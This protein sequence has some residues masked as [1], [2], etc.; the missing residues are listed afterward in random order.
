[1]T[2]LEFSRPVR[3]RDL[4][5]DEMVLEISAKAEECEALARR[6]GI[7]ALE[8]LD[9]T[10]CLRPESRVVVSLRAQLTADAVQ[11]CVVTLAPVPSRIETAF[12]RLYS[13][14]PER[15]KEAL[16]EELLGAEDPPDAIE[17]GIIDVGEAVA[18][19]LALELDPFPRA[20]GITFDGFTT[21]SKAERA[22]T[23]RALNPF[24]TLDRLKK[25][26]E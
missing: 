14:L 25:D 8:K 20:S 6:F 16:E 24:A 15:D 7:I 3:V 21:E 23:D 1:M 19:Q 9:A 11:A 26:L 22:E 17:D 4:K 2:T 12:T 5:N 13:S 10:V 18:E